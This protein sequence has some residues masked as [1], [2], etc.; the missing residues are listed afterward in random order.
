MQLDKLRALRQGHHRIVSTQL[1]RLG[2]NLSDFEKSQLIDIL[3][4]KAEIIRALNEK[5]VN[6]NDIDDIAGE[7]FDGED[8]IIRLDMQIGKL[9]ESLRKKESSQTNQ[10]E[11]AATTITLEDTIAQ[12]ERFNNACTSVS[13]G[14]PTRGELFTGNNRTDHNS[15][16]YTDSLNSSSYHRLPKLQMPEFDGEI[17]EWQ[18]F[19]NSYE[20]KVVVDS[21][22]QVR[23][24]F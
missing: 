5:I 15:V 20:C 13:A 24:V 14:T 21:N 2:D 12:G 17:A 10:K 16:S 4:A 1:E 7:L 23:V 8:Y 6:H 18:T 3:S 22:L 11:P 19:W 9:R